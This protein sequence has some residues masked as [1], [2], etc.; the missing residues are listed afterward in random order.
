MCQYKELGGY[1]Y[2]IDAFVLPRYSDYERIRYRG[3]I[4]I[5]RLPNTERMM[6]EAVIIFTTHDE[7]TKIDAICLAESE[8]DEYVRI[9]AMRS[10][11]HL[12]RDRERR[13]PISFG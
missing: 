11:I 4:H 6:E 1:Y 10:M 2:W 3:R 12:A 13:S 7:N 8:I 9:D 5:V